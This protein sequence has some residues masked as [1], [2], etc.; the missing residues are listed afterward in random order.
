MCSIRS[1]VCCISMKQF[2]GSFVHLFFSNCTSEYLTF[3]TAFFLLF[4]LSIHFTTF[5]NGH[6]HRQEL[7]ETIKQQANADVKIDLGICQ[8]SHTHKHTYSLPKKSVVLS[9]FVHCIL[10]DFVSFFSSM[11][12]I[13]K[14]LIDRKSDIGSLGAGA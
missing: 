3:F 14:T 8:L 9:Q 6:L 1:I 10:M 2:V 13:E 11:Q 5:L 4:F 7:F 12:I